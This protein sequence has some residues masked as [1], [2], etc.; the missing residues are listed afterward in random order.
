MLHGVGDVGGD[1]GIERDIVVDGGQK[2]DGH[3]FRQVFAHG[4]GVEDVF[5]VTLHIH[6]SRRHAGDGMDFGDG[7]DGIK[8][9]VLAHDCGPLTGFENI[10][11]PVFSKFRANCA[12]PLSAGRKER[13]RSAGPLQFCN[14]PKFALHICNN[15]SPKV[16]SVKLGK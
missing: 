1:F 6:R 8:T 10:V 4:F 11:A 15:I 9:G 12:L 14:K 16:H 5:G 3:G 2:F 13:D 7:I